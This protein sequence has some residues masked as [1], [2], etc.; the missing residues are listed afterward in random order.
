MR[1]LAR[2]LLNAATALSLVLC[3]A[4]LVLWAK[5][6]NGYPSVSWAS[7]LRTPGQATGIRTSHVTAR[8]GTLWIVRTD[9]WL[10]VPE[11][12]R[13]ITGPARAARPVVVEPRWP[14]LQ[15]TYEVERQAA[16]T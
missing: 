4:T 11:A 12:R 9:G 3:A 16:L 7:G 5:S 8:S 10:D 14:D 6:R 13:A 1:R 2:L 15:G